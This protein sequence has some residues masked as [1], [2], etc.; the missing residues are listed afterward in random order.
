MG[1]A[2]HLLG[3]KPDDWAGLTVE[4][5]DALLDWLDAYK[6]AQDEA[7]QKMRR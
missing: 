2:A 3:I 4:E 6:A 5:T 7:E 1:N